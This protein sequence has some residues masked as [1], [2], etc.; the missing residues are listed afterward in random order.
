[1]KEEKEKVE[2]IVDYWPNGQKRC[3]FSHIKGKKHGIEMHWHD[4]GKKRCE[5]PWV[6]EQSHGIS[7]CWNENGSLQFVRKWNQGQ[8]VVGFKFKD[9]E[10]PEGRVPE[11]DI[12]TK[13]FKLL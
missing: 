1:M 13:E 9:S 6:N 2:W 5:I 8:L 3:E 4:N 10:V 7:T 11:I 12:L